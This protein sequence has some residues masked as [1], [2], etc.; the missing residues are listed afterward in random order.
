MKRIVL[1]QVLLIA[2]Q[3]IAFNQVPQTFNY[4]A[5]ARNQQGDPLGDQSL[6]V[7]IGILQNGGLIW[8]EDHQPPLRDLFEGLA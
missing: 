7:R 3:T 2:M 5:I 1:F 4:Q 8:Q 6:M